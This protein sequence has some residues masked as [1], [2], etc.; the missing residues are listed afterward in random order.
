MCLFK[1]LS[2]GKRQAWKHASG[3]I[4]FTHS[5][6]RMAGSNVTYGNGLR[7]DVFLMSAGFLFE[8][9]LLFSVKFSF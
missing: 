3:L 5:L 7:Y 1:A 2:G 9:G 6:H 4:F 8:G